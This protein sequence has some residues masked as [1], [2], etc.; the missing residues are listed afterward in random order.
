[1]PAVLRRWSPAG[2]PS[3]VGNSR[4]RHRSPPRRLI[5]FAATAGNRCA[6]TAWSMTRDPSTLLMSTVGDD[7]S[8]WVFGVPLD[9]AHPTAMSA[10][11]PA[12][13][14]APDLYQSVDNATETVQGSSVTC[15][16]GSARTTVTDHRMTA[17]CT[18][19]P[20]A[21]HAGAE[22]E[23]LAFCS[24]CIKDGSGDDH[25][26]AD[27][28]RFTRVTSAIPMWPA[29]SSGDVCR[30]RRRRTLQSGMVSCCSPAAGIPPVPR[31]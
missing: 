1:M 17:R 29:A 30:A 22:R 6:S 14:T 5:R 15:V 18:V 9:L 4:L 12:S 21:G 3:H 13:R 8:G 24:A 28:G 2:G 11:A 26:A 20:A 23:R 10:P 19:A 7:A 16:P 31:C 27:V 25:R